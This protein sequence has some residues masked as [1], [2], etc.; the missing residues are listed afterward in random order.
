M[1]ARLIC[2]EHV[3]GEMVHYPTKL[4]FLLLFVELILLLLCCL[5]MDELDL[6][7]QGGKAVDE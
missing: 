5:Q 7:T 4:V 2:L 6:A 3:P 1:D